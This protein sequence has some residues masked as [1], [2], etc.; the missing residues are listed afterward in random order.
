MRGDNEIS[1]AVSA[2]A[3]GMGPESVTLDAV[4]STTGGLDD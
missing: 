1:I 3:A 2:K 4:H